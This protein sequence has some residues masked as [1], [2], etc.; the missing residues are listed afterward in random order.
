MSI[1]RRAFA[2]GLAGVLA[3][4]LIPAARAE[5]ALQEGRDWRAL[6]PPQP[7]ADRERIEVLEFFSYGCPHCGGLNPLIKTWADA[8]PEDVAFQRVP[9]TFGRAAWANLARLFYALEA[10]DLLSELDQAVFE[11]I[12]EQRVNLYTD[13]NILKWIE[14]QGHDPEAFG[15]TLNSFEVDAAT[16][17]AQDLESRMRIDA[18]P[19][20]VVDGRYVVVGEGVR[21]YAG[22]L[23]I[24]D[25]LIAR[26]REAR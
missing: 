22:L 18:V 26:A 14:Q 8:L 12:T 20:I 13:K 23:R 25:A 6:S 4:T 21:G 15:K 11:A 1:N 2:T 17:R 24:A 10:D 9:V 19:R 16:R 3:A 5:D 7:R